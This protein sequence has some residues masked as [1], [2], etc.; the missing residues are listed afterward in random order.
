MLNTDVIREWI[1]RLRNTLRA[2]RADADLEDELTSHLAL[3][4]D[5]ARRRGE[6]PDVAGRVTRLAAGGTAQAMERL[7]DQRGLP[8]LEDLGRDLRYAAR[9]MSRDIA[10]TAVALL[11]LALGIGVNTA[12]FTAYKAMVLRPLDARDARRMVNVAL[13]RRSGATDFTFS[14]PDY[15]TYRDSVRSFSGLV[16]FLPERMTLSNAGGMVS[17]RTAASESALGKLGLLSPGTANAEF[18]SVF[19][20]SEN[21][22][23]VLGVAP[24]GGRTF[25]SIGVSGLRAAPSVLISENYWQRRFGRD[26]ALVGQAIRLNGASVAIVGITPRDFIGTGAAVPDFWLPLSLEPLV[27]ADENWLRDREAGRYRL[28]ARL[29]DGAGASQG[30][31]EMTVVADRLR[32]LHDPRSDSAKSA[33]ALVWPGSPFPL[34]LAQYRGL[35]LTILLIMAAAG[36][37]LAVACAN[38]ASL[39]LARGR[40]RAAELRTRLSLGAS[41]PRLI[42]QLLTESVLLAVAGGAV[43]LFCAWAFL[44]VAVTL[45]AEA[46]PAGDGTPVFHVMPDLTVF[47]YVFATSL[48][49]GVFFGL[50]PALESSR[51]GIASGRTST[52]S[53]GSRRL[54]DILVAA[55]VSLSLVLLIA[56]SLLIRSAMQSLRTDPGYD[57][58]HVI[59]LEVQFPEAS[60]YTASHRTTTLR[61]LR[62]RLAAFPA[63]ASMT[64]ARPPAANGFRTAAMSVDGPPAQPRVQSLFYYS[65]V[66]PNYFDTLGIP[67]LLGRAFQPSEPEHSVILSES[68]AALLWPGQSA[69]GRSLRL[70]LTDEHVHNASELVAD[71]PVYQVVGVARDTRGIEF[72]GSGSKQAYLPSTGERTR[73]RPILVRTKSDPAE[74]VRAVEPAV[75]SIDPDLL[76]TASTLEEQLRQSGPFIVSSLMAVVA[77]AIGSVGLLLAA[78][79]IYGTVRYIV[80][81]RTREVGVRMAIGA[82][83]RDIIGLILR[84]TARPVVAGLL[85]GMLMAAGASYLLRGFLYGISTV[86]GVS[87]G[88]VSLSFLAIA[89][90]AA[91][92]PSRRA[93]RVDPMIALRDD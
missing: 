23:A 11:A 3:A 80:V 51:A 38:V 87:F 10:F 43:A 53:A 84:E 74:V 86:D 71:G 35:T 27:H 39:Q 57:S 61:D 15:E 7:R 25:E 24:F 52:S 33:T 64:S 58:R 54:Q 22:F 13:V 50:A 91:Y 17:Q 1:G 37:V 8:W 76:T 30:Q 62:A 85:A 93:T 70:G 55:Q 90:L 16:A 56:G 12:V 46:I 75:A 28:F 2:T 19:G 79:G 68:A 40:S 59:D 32:G 48:A 72:D 78:M 89:L 73:I 29:A 49:A 45:F 18:V 83:K 69:I 81:L 5:E 41:R 63:V 44:R 36:M 88:G 14:Y 82:Q 20:V 77:M 92:T 47:T 31:A 6:P 9:M 60:K 65:Y 21:Y 42:R 34:P 4:D 26:P 67:V 66:E